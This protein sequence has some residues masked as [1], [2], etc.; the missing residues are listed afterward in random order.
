LQNGVTPLKAWMS[1]LRGWETFVASNFALRPGCK[2]SPDTAL[3][4]KNLWRSLAL[5]TNDSLV[6]LCLEPLENRT[7]YNPYDRIVCWAEITEEAG[8]D[9]ICSC[10]YNLRLSLQLDN[11]AIPAS[12]P[13]MFDNVF[14]PGTFTLQIALHNPIP[15]REA[16]FTA[17]SNDAYKLARASPTSL[18]AWLSAGQRILRRGTTYEI[19]S[20]EQ[21]GMLYRLESSAPV[22][23]GYVKAGFTTIIVTFASNDQSTSASLNFSSIKDPSCGSDGFEID[24]DFLASYIQCLPPNTLPIACHK[25]EQLLPSA[26]CFLPIPRCSYPYENDNDATVYVCTSDLIRL[27]V[28]DGDWVREA[29]VL[30]D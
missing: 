17:L 8:F 5:G 6:C 21:N 1:L 9:D 15:L 7:R 14:G 11:I 29:I 23:Q 2:E 4:G 10:T 28:L 24:E 3:I 13:T 22:L 18:E 27:G 19:D 25:K 30:Y 16:I 20:F 12:W 26:N